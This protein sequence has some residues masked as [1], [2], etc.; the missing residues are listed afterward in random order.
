ML[1]AVRLDAPK[2]DNNNAINTRVMRSKT[3]TPRNCRNGRCANFVNMF[4]KTDDVTEL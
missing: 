3:D 1:A 2:V 4:M